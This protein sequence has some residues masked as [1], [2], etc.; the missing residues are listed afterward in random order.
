MIS[1]TIQNILM[2]FSK[3]ILFDLVLIELS[4]QII[5]K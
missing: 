1:K 4:N 5:I 3:M 2:D